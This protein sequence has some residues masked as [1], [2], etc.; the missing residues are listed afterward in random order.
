MARRHRRL[1]KAQDKLPKEAYNIATGRSMASQFGPRAANVDP[2]TSQWL[3][4]LNTFPN[5]IHPGVGMLT[6]S[7]L[8]SMARVPYVASIIMTRMNQASDFAFAQPDPYSL[9]HVIQPI[10][11]G[12]P[13][14]RKDRVI[15]GEIQEMVLNA[16][17]KYFPGGF[18]AALR[19]IVADT[20]TFDQVNVEPLMDHATQKPY[21]Y[22]PVDPS[23]IRRAVPDRKVLADLRWDYDETAFVQVINNRIVREFNRH[24]LSWWIRNQESGIYRYGYGAP[25]LEK[26]V[27]IVAALINAII[28]N[29]VNYTTGIHS[30]NIIEAAI[31][32]NEE[33]VGT[34][35]KLISS[36]VSGPRQSRR[37]P[38]IQVNPNLQEYLKVHPLGSTNKE[39]EFSEWIN[40]LKKQLASLFQMDPAELGDIFGNEGQKQQMNQTSPSDRI[41]A[42]KERGL[43]PLMRRIARWFNDFLIKPYWPGYQLVFTG[44][45]AQSEEKKLEMDLKAVT[46]IV[47]PNEL[48]AER[49]LDP[50]DDPVS[51][52]PL[53]A[54][55]TAYIQNE[56]DNQGGGLGVEDD[57]SSIL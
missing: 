1:S 16:G 3:T 12:R 23:T 24:D 15:M 9:G 30:Q 36:S 2:L 35:E 25:E 44:F 46:A 20:L 33:R 43:R 40:F 5:D 48:R 8:R 6:Y 13:L 31:L 49:G 39:M 53:N 57:L 45:D 54:L 22:C 56:L 11:K 21:G 34:L 18:E 10:D 28:H 55:Y 26:A 47:S 19:Q 29:T 38:V 4:S 14:T 32:G 52:R 17:D 27:S 41:F 42:S 7:H 51:E 37:T 50:Y